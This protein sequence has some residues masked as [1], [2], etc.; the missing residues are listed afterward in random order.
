MSATGVVI[1]IQ[2]SGVITFSAETCVGCG[3][4][5]LMCA[6][7]HEGVGGPALARCRVLRDPFE[8]EYQFI[9]CQQCLAP[10]CYV[11]C[12]NRDQA[13]CIDERTGARYID[14]DLCVV[15]E[16][17]VRECPFEPSR[18]FQHPD[19]KVPYKCD[20]CKDREQGP[21]CVEYC[22]VSALTYVLAERR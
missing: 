15:A 13:L 12:P 17:C 1:E 11:A 21:I 7:H 10:S 14:E 4:C 22:P 16:E 6:L 18:V 5:E 2:K 9:T 20:L 19:K 3:T 8:A